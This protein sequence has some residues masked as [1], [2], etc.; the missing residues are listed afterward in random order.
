MQ[1]GEP[2]GPSEGGDAE[3]EVADEG[4]RARVSALID[5]IDVDELWRN[6]RERGLAEYDKIVDDN[7]TTYWGLV[8]HFVF[9][10]IEAVRAATPPI[11]LSYDHVCQAVQRLI[12]VGL[13][14][15]KGD[16]AMEQQLDIIA[17]SCFFR[18]VTFPDCTE[19]NFQ[20]DMWIEF[21][22]RAIARLKASPW[23]GIDEDEVNEI[24]RGIMEELFARVD[25]VAQIYGFTEDAIAEY[26]LGFSDVMNQI[27]GVKFHLQDQGY[28]VSMLEE[29]L[30]AIAVKPEDTDPKKVI[31]DLAINMAELLM[32]HADFIVNYYEQGHPTGLQL[33]TPKQVVEYIYRAM[34]KKLSGQA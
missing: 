19:G 34:L 9:K 18:A 26:K 33:T 30:Y 11:Q 13:M 27:V 8:T 22:K 32:F 6:F 3:A 4:E 28:F 16:A 1:N 21:Q 7:R 14:P 31:N 25:V 20:M 15:F 5:G 23:R 24:G 10:A 17:E 29:S 12:T 2:E